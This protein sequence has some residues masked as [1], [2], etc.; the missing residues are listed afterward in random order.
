MCWG[1]ADAENKLPLLPPRPPPPIVEN[2]EI[3]SKVPSLK[4][5]AG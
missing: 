1:A 3:L 2:Y 5:R 4:P